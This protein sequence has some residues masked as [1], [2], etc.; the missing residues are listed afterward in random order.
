M[1]ELLL[2]EMRLQRKKLYLMHL[3]VLEENKL[4]KDVEGLG[5][6]LVKLAMRQELDLPLLAF[7]VMMAKRNR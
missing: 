3:R 5:A 2:L 6:R 4:G 7:L 1:T